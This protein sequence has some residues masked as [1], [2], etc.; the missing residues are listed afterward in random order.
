MRSNG[1]MGA[2]WGI[3]ISMF[4]NK[5]NIIPDL[6]SSGIRSDPGGQINKLKNTKQYIPGAKLFAASSTSMSTNVLATSPARSL[7]SIKQPFDLYISDYNATTPTAM[8][9]EK[10]NASRAQF[11]GALVLFHLPNQSRTTEVKS[12]PLKLHPFSLAPAS[13]LL[14]SALGQQWL[15]SGM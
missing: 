15:R 14:P 2:N 11:C 8:P 4:K 10:S 9:K 3:E 13:E 1:R 12:K 7:Y 6:V 5:Q